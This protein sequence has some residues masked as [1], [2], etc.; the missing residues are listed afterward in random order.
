MK[1]NIAIDGPSASGKS[2]I[3]KALAK[4]LNYTHLDTGAMYRACAYKAL[5]NGI[6]TDNEDDLV[7]MVNS[8]HFAF[9]D[10]GQILLD[11]VNISSDIRSKEIDLL[12]SKIA[13]YAQVRASLVKIQQFMAKNKGYIL[14]GRDIG[15][16]VLPDAEVK[17]FQT[18]SIESRA[19]RRLLDYQNKGI[20]IDYQT[21]YN[22]IEL[23]DY[24]DQNREHSPLR[25]TDNAFVLDTSNLS[26]NESVD[27]VYDLVI[28]KI[29]EGSD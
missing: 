25:K 14:D 5:K 18:A 9:D 11:G 28:K 16:V 8:S 6:N 1:L 4:R 21:I 23:R 20:K 10:L 12:T 19:K 26:I 22:E 27:I 2:T 7:K 13:R 17:I 29:N 24:Q 3:A 15:T